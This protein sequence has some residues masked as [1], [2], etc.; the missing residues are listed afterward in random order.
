MRKLLCEKIRVGRIGV[1]LQQG[2]HRCLVRCHVGRRRPGQPSDDQAGV[3]EDD[4]DPQ[5]FQY[6]GTPKH[7]FLPGNL[8]RPRTLTV[9]D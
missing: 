1:E 8:F 4:T 7:L 2:P 6:Q 5:A 9:T 3:I